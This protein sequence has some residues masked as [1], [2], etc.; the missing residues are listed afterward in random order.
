MGFQQSPIIV[1]TE[2]SV[3]ITQKAVGTTSQEAQDD[4]K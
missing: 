1:P 2:S 4:K 3:T